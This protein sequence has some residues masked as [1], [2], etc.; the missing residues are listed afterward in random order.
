MIIGTFVPSINPHDNNLESKRRG[1]AFAKLSPKLG[2]S[3]SIFSTVRISVLLRSCVKTS[4][5][6]VAALCSTGERN[7]RRVHIVLCSLEVFLARHRQS[8]SLSPA[9]AGSNELLFMFTKIMTGK[10]RNCFNQMSLEA[11]TPNVF[12]DL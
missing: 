5:S 3:W 1:E 8:P 7:S 9:R 6:I 4:S 2:N 10:S 12:V 11:G